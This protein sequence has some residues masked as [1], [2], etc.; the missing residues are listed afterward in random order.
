MTAATEGAAYSCFTDAW[1]GRLRA[2]LKADFAVVDT[3]WTSEDLLKAQVC[4]TWF[5]EKKVYDCDDEGR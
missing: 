2:G 3:I 1:T 5:E 4:Q